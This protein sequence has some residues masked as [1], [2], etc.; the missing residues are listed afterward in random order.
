MFTRQTGILAFAT[1]V[2]IL[3]FAVPSFAMEPPIVLDPPVILDVLSEDGAKSEIHYKGQAAK[4]GKIDL[5]ATNGFF[6]G[7]FQALD[8]QPILQGDQGLIG[9][10][11][12]Y[13]GRLSDQIRG[14]ARWHLWCPSAGEIKATFFMLVPAAE[15]DHPWS[16]K[17][18]DETRALKVHASDGQSP[19]KQT[20]AFTV[21]RAG[22]VTFAV[23]C[24]TTPPAAETRIYFIRLEGSAVKGASLLRTRWRPAAVHVH[25]VAPQTC[26]GPRMWVFETVNLRKTRSFSPLTTPFGYFGIVFENGGRIR[27]GAKFA[28]SMWIPT[29]DPTK[30]P[31]IASMPRL[32][33]TDLP[34]AQYS[35]FGGEGSGVKFENAAAY[36]NGADRA[37]QALRME[38]TGDLRTFFGYFYDEQEHHWKLFASAQRLKKRANNGPL[39]AEIGSF[40]E[41]PGPANVERSG[42]MVRESKR[43]GWFYGSDRQWYRA[44]LK[45]DEQDLQKPADTAVPETGPV[46]KSRPHK[47]PHKVIADSPRISDQRAYYMQDYSAEGWMAMATG[48]MDFH[49]DDRSHR[50]KPIPNDGRPAPLPEYLSPEKISQLFELPVDFGVSKAS[51]VSSDHATIDIEIKKTGANSKAIL[52]YGTVDCLTYLPKKVDKGSAIEIDMYRPERTWQ[53]ATPEQ[54]VATGTNRFV[55]NGLKPGTTYY[56]RPFVVHDRGKS[57]DYQSG[58]FKTAEASVLGN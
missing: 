47:K 17:L 32:I 19:Q 3:L 18:G 24:T 37:I 9:Y 2:P 27:P 53:S 57:W 43:R 25:Y 4:Q 26:P 1:R 22:K 31:P 11:F 41:I 51:E 39:L 56:Y 44:Q 49:R 40:C 6:D 10:S 36:K 55:L 42:D 52:Y 20:L 21:E 34:E 33:G 50:E 45:S 13:L 58:S 54:K 29:H 7:C 5:T 23:D 35:T 38:T 15:A 48:G 30:A 46:K 16:I 12:G 28:F 8:Q 14:T